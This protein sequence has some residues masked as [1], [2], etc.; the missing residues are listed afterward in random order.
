MAINL[1]NQSWRRDLL[2]DVLYH[3]LVELQHYSMVSSWRIHCISIPLNTNLHLTSVDH[4]GMKCL[5][6]GYNIETLGWTH[7]NIANPI[8][9]NFFNGVPTREGRH[10]IFLYIGV[11]LLWQTFYSKNIFKWNNGFKWISMTTNWAKLLLKLNQYIFVLR[12]NSKLF[13]VSHFFNLVFEKILSIFLK[14]LLSFSQEFYNIFLGLKKTKKTNEMCN[15]F[16]G[17]SLANFI[18]IFITKPF[19]KR[20]IQKSSG[21][22]YF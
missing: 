9:C 16:C 3:Y 5:V 11:R 19:I 17:K 12:E 2:I 14:Y 1:R 7:K 6:Q 13:F 10:V 20:F 18:I 8:S 22:L 4:T 15:F 21:S